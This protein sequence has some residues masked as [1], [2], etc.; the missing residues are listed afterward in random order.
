MPLRP[1]ASR[2]LKVAPGHRLAKR[3]KDFVTE[4]F[5]VR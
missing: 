3:E 2:V 5:G 4:R 1:R